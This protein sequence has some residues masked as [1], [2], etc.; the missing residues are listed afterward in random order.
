MSWREKCGIFLPSMFGS[1]SDE[2]ISAPVNTLIP[3]TCSSVYTPPM[4]ILVTGGSGFLGSTCREILAQRPDIQVTVLR[5]GYGPTP[6]ETS[7]SSIEAPSSLSAQDLSRSLGSVTITHIVHIGALSSPET[8][9]REPERADYSNVRF[10]KMLAEYAIGIG[11]HLT[12]VSTDLVFDGAKAPE[13]GFTE[14]CQPCPNSVYSRSKLLAEEATLKTPSNA[15]I[16]VSLLYGHTSSPSLG[17]LGW[18]ERAFREDYPLNLFSDEYRTPT[19]VADAAHATLTISERSLSGIWHCGG[20][21]RLSRVEFGTLVAQ[22][23]GYDAS[24]IR[25]TSRRTL[26]NGPTRPEDVSLNS[27]KLWGAL[28]MRPRGVGEA[29]G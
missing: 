11:A 21:A 1:R 16:R 15:V 22:A 18:M 23:L 27:E 26:T 2:A 3:V 17:V 29:L 25:P 10:T 12:T 6:S 4:R 9:E 8:C 7:V 28:G 24:L 20:P 14:R 19:H 5:S 13:G